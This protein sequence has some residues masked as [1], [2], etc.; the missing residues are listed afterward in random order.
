MS[1]LH[2]WRASFLIQRL[3][4][5]TLKS[6]LRSWVRVVRY[7]YNY[8]E[9]NLSGGPALHL[10]NTFDTDRLKS[11]KAADNTPVTHLQKQTTGTCNFSLDRQLLVKISLIWLCR[12]NWEIHKYILTK[13]KTKNLA[14]H[15][16]T[17]VSGLD[18]WR[19]V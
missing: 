8:T 4:W 14:K 1:Q 5:D 3:A 16:R 6:T 17:Y 18:Y 11:S 10:G 15:L 13:C 7:H 19:T 2:V 12:H 9:K